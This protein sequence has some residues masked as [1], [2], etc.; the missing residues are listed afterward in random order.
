MSN[1]PPFVKSLAF[2]TAV[3]WLAAGV[4]ALLAYF[5]VVAESWAVPAAAILSWVLALLNMFGIKPELR[6]R[7]A[8]KALQAQG[9]LPK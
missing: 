5:G 3:S 1:L 4:L 9:L 6:Y 7:A 2:W 8:V